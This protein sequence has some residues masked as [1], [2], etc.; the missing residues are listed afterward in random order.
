MLLQ[1]ILNRDPDT[2]IAVSGSGSSG[3]ETSYFGNLTMLAV[4]KFQ[5]KYGIAKAGDPGYGF[6]GPKTRAKLATFLTVT[7]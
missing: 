2:M 1:K 7:P 3:F 4:E 5:V 6:V